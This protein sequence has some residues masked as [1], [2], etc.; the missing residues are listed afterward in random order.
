MKMKEMNTYRKSGITVGTSFTLAAVTAIIGLD[1]YGPI[2]H[3]L[4]TLWLPSESMEQKL[5]QFQR[6][7]SVRASLPDWRIAKA[8]NS[9]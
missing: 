3:D 8:L 2:S 4:L 6:F 5:H 9:M 7:L 1:L